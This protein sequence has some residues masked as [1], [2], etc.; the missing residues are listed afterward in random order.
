MDAKFPLVLAAGLSMG[1]LAQPAHAPREVRVD[2]GAY[3]RRGAIVSF[4]LQDS[5]P[6]LQ[7]RL[8]DGTSSVPVQVDQSGRA[9]FVAPHL[10][11]GTSRSYRLEE[12]ADARP[13]RVT[14]RREGDNVAIAAGTPVLQYVGGAGQ[15]PSADIK[16]I[17]KRGGYLHPVRT[18]SGRI[19][20]DDYPVDHRHHH[21]VWFAWTKTAFQGRE[22]DFWNMGDGKGRVEFDSLKDVWSGPVHAGLRA[23]H[24]YI[25]LTSGSP[26]VV[27][28][29]QWDTRVF[30]PGA[31]DEGRGLPY[32]AF[33]LEVVQTNVAAD[34]LLLPEYHY[35]GVGV[36]GAASFVKPDNVTFLTS[37]GKDRATGD[38][39][40]SRWAVMSGS[41][42]G[43]RASLAILAHPD[44]FRA[45]E[46]MRIHRTDPY[47]C[48]APSRSG[49]WA[50]ARGT[51]HRA[52][53]RFVAFDG[54]PDPAEL[55]RLWVDYA[56]PPTA[57]VR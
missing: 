2:A 41:V 23:T 13:P 8:S 35:G 48:Y 18:P 43:E 30:A 42:E 19:V 14:A 27:L 49:P 34:P 31:A 53:Y 52:R 4:A 16:P 32:H 55:H 50:I 12:S 5:R 56:Q 57:S 21:G 10:K 3:D 7:Y 1:W 37:E 47:L 6:G 44:N 17:F 22:P 9:W 11:A 26:I 33:D 39:T 45:P 51:A 28:S 40:E 25:D 46:R 15:L 36:R 24:R 38:G 29:E 54:A 20:T